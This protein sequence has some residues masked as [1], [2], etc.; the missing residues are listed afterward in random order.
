MRDVE[1][2]FAAALAECAARPDFQSPP[3]IERFRAEAIRTTIRARA[4]GIAESIG[5]A[6]PE[7]W[8]RAPL[9]DGDRSAHSLG[10]A[11]EHLVGLG[12]RIGAE[13]PEI[14]RDS[15]RRRRLG[16]YYTP[17]AL[18]A[19]LVNRALESQ[20]LTALGLRVLD[21]AAGAGVFLL[22][23]VDRIALLVMS[24]APRR[25]GRVGDRLLDERRATLPGGGEVSDDRIARL[26]IAQSCVFGMDIDPLA[27]EVARLSLWL[28]AG[29]P[30]VPHTAFDRCVRTG[31]ALRDGPESDWSDV[32]PDGFDGVVGN[33]P[34]LN[35]LESATARSAADNARLR[36]SLGL[37][38]APYTDT[39][40]LF[41]LRALAQCGVRGRVCMIQPLSL[42]AARDAAPVRR[43]CVARASLASI[44]LDDER[45]FRGAAV[46]V[47]APCLERPARAE[48]STSVL[49]GPDDRPV[50][51][52]RSLARDFDDG[53]QWASIVVGGPIGPQSRRAPMRT[54]ADYAEATA[55][56]RDQYY[57]LRGMIV[58]DDEIADRAD[59]E[60]RYPRLITTGLIDLGRTFWGVR[61]TR[62]DRRP[63]RAP[64]V[65]L[66]RLRAE[67]DLGAWADRRLVPK[68]LLATQTR[69]LEVVV[70][71]AG[72]WLPLV[73]IITIT[74]RDGV[75]PW[76]LAAAIASPSNLCRALSEQFGAALS[77]DAVKL[78]ATQALGL[79]IPSL[80]RRNAAAAR[81]IFRRLGSVQDDAARRELLEAMGHSLFGCE[82]FPPGPVLRRSL[83]EDWL[84]RLTPR[85]GRVGRRTT[86]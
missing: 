53:R 25:R 31:D 73:P 65:D 49:T 77:A 63:W 79:T 84:D 18:A 13:G 66:A 3:D 68:I 33:P 57:G 52:V 78:S 17:R 5:L 40:G 76:T 71:E 80:D 82:A 62:F 72:L 38:N 14:V 86:C 69:A 11:Y 59:I 6:P 26:L 43:A 75:C 55:D 56:F 42:L 32:A 21:P 30:G 12:V 64:R 36:E 74:P 19:R 54:V 4:G 45:E 41:L 22:E 20:R 23:A 37:G 27:V 50:R 28:H 15:E 2:E 85:Q 44:W 48:W 35:Q 70:D 9:G 34:F 46:R 10:A 47:C 29:V 58:E 8:G 60:R 67:S 24:L 39:A 1:R 16:A 83:L 7:E 61:P 81:D 51:T